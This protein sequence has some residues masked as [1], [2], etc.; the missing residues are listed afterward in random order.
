[1]T[2]EILDTFE[3][4]SDRKRM[5]IILKSESGEII[6]FAKGAD[7]VMIPR[8]SSGSKS[9]LCH[10]EAHLDRFASVG[11]RTLLFGKKILTPEEYKLFKQ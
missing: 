2:Y 3:F 11:L 10:V 1:M 9:E 7:S 4:T 6:M 5:S 8:M